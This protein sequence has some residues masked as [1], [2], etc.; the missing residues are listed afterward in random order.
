MKR[1]ASLAEIAGVPLISLVLVVLLTVGGYYSFQICMDQKREC[2]QKLAE[3]RL[4]ERQ[5]RDLSTQNAV[6]KARHQRLRT[7]EGMEEVA[8]E[9]LGMV[10]PGEI[11]YVVE[12]GPPAPGPEE[13]LARPDPPEPA[14]GLLQR[15]LNRLL[16]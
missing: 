4:V 8:R 15:A 2:R 3:L 5:I 11:A 6:L 16:F 14:P 10:R 9:K 12:P 1:R 13:L 7:A